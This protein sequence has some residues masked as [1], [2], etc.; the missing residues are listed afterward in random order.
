MK[1]LGGPLAALLLIC[2]Q[3][4]T[5]GAYTCED[6]INDDATSAEAGLLIDLAW[7]LKFT[8]QVASQLD[9][10][11]D[12]H[13]ATTLLVQRY[14]PGAGPGT[15]IERAP[16]SSGGDCD[17]ARVVIEPDG[18][19]TW[20]PTDK[21][22]AATPANTFCLRDPVDPKLSWGP[23]AIVA[24]RRARQRERDSICFA[25]K[26]GS[27]YAGPALDR[28][29]NDATGVIKVWAAPPASALAQPLNQ[30]NDD[31]K[32]KLSDGI[33]AWLRHKWAVYLQADVGA[34]TT[35]AE[36]KKK[37]SFDDFAKG[38]CGHELGKPNLPLAKDEAMF[39]PCGEPAFRTQLEAV[40]GEF[41]ELET[42]VNAVND[43]KPFP[44]ALAAK[45]CQFA[46][47]SSLASSLP[48]DK[49]LTSA[50]RLLILRAQ[51]HGETAVPSPVFAGQFPLSDAPRLVEITPQAP[52]KRVIKTKFFAGDMILVF[53]HDLLR[54][55][56]KDHPG[57]IAAVF[58]GK[59][60]TQEG[61]EV[62]QV[63]YAIFKALASAEGI[64][65]TGGGGAVRT[66]AECDALPDSGQQLYCRL[67]VERV[68]DETELH[69]ALEKQDETRGVV[70]WIKALAIIGRKRPGISQQTQ[71]L[72]DA[73]Y[74]AH[75]RDPALLG[76]PIP[77]I[78]GDPSAPLYSTV[79]RAEDVQ[80]GYEYDVRICHDVAKCDASV[81]E[82][83]VSAAAIVKVPA[84][85][86][87]VGTA[88]ELSWAVYSTPG[89][90]LGGYTFDP[91]GGPAG[92]QAFYQLRG[93]N[94]VQDQFTFSQLVLL[95]PVALAQKLKRARDAWP[96]FAV[97]GGPS[98]FTASQA[99]FLKQWNFRIGFEVLPSFLITLGFSARQIDAPSGRFMAG[100]IVAV[101]PK[102]P[103]PQFEQSHPWA[104]QLSLGLAVDLATAGKLISDAATSS[105]KSAPDTPSG[106]GNKS[107][108]GGK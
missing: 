10:A 44:T 53:A 62:A 82:S 91:I 25:A 33:G 3:A 89:V 17:G 32:K 23:T 95:Y 14:C 73:A 92:A 86:L 30:A 20:Q 93:H 58:Q 1:R 105:Q 106:G 16:L 66:L 96:G 43:Q 57:Q 90:P 41:A 69:Q 42:S 60:L 37:V 8:R 74:V 39:K 97:G 64:T 85:H 2:L 52:A 51:A 6:K 38:V 7:A 61:T 103:A 72:L 70:F 27:V 100:D 98:L 28:D 63:F 36:L 55:T 81:D 35:P 19:I 76:D 26:S 107:T 79:L 83:S 108:G 18:T 15:A 13:D 59:Q 68:S 78:A 80:D 21:H 94:S 65:L 11:L 50:E 54:A 71:K 4:R 31:A 101:G 104:W 49:D 102:D 40:H 84:A 75:L 24:L 99:L 22:K 67:K 87:I 56:D 45:I 34:A 5:A 88:T 48:A 77:I 47:K 12:R 46:D 29:D 9:G